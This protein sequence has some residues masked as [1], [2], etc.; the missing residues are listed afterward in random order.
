MIVNG[1]EYADYEDYKKRRGEQQTNEEWLHTLNTEQLAE[2]LTRISDNEWKY[3]VMPSR[4][5]E[6]LE[7]LK[8]PYREE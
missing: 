3:P 7:W 8:Q 1:V 6:W 4:M 2:L 5:Q